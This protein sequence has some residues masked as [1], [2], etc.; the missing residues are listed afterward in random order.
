MLF[1]PVAEGGSH[2]DT[3]HSGVNGKSSLFPSYRMI[4]S[5]DLS[6]STCVSHG[7]G[8]A[9]DMTAALDVLG[10]I[11]KRSKGVRKNF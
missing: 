2:V 5:S 10:V 8:S 11:C 7:Q 6:C 1:I 3:R 4:Y 9:S